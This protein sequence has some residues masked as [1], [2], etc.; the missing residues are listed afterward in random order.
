MSTYHCRV[1]SAGDELGRVGVELKGLE[2][3]GGKKGGVVQTTQELK[4]EPS[5][6]VAQPWRTLGIEP[7]ER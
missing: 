1:E 6:R 4:R 2:R 7:M 3:D 5:V